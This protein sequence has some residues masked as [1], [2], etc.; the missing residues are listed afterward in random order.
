M[1]LVGDRHAVDDEDRLI[2][3][4]NR[5]RTTDDDVGRS[6]LSA[7]T[8]DCDTR[9]LALELLDYVQRLGLIDFCSELL[10]S[11]PRRSSLL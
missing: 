6:A 1:I 2:I 10:L 8:G 5:V 3:T 4:G 7:R 9:D 11:L